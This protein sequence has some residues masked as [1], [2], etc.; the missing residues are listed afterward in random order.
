MTTL[1]VLGVPIRDRQMLSEKLLWMVHHRLNDHEGWVQR[2]GEIADYLTNLVAERRTAAER[3]DDLLQ[4]LIEEEFDGRM[5]TDTEG[6]QVLI[7][8]LFGA[9]DSTSSAMSGS[10][11]H[12]GQNPEDKQRLLS[13]EVAWEGA[14]EEFLRFT[15]PIQ[16][17]RR[18]VTKETELDGGTLQPGDFVLALQRGGESRSGQVPRTRQV[19]DLTRRARAYV[20]RHRRPC[21]HRPALCAGDDR[22]LP[23]DRAAADRRLSDR[24]RVRARLHVE[25]GAGAED[26]AGRFYARSGERPIGC[27]GGDVF[28]GRSPRAQVL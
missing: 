18:T 26:A 13:G 12:L 22:H 23:Q 9:L 27:P 2:Y 14:I 16:A 4:C 1:P 10:L 19:R 17:L 11:Y 25:R 24:R 8:A 7:L 5:L 20:V 3:R 6:Y 28:R 15:T 21:L